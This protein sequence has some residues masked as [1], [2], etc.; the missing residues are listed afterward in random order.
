[1]KRIISLLTLF[2]LLCSSCTKDD[3]ERKDIYRYYPMSSN[4]K[5]ILPYKYSDTMVWINVNTKDT[6]HYVWK[7]TIYSTDTLVN[8][9]NE[10]CVGDT[11]S[12]V[13]KY[14]YGFRCIENS[15]YNFTHYYRKYVLGDDF[16]TGLFFNKRN[17]VWLDITKPNIDNFGVIYSNIFCTEYFSFNN[18][19]GLLRITVGNT[20]LYRIK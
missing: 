8:S 16:E 12:I 6:L 2:I 15:N 17:Y 9:S 13:G 7:D 1:M 19:D 4:E 18:K 5:A 10:D 3:C 14:S 11:Y 20:K